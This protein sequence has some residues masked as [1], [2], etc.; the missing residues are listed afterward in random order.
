M[1]RF[2]VRS[3]IPTIALTLFAAGTL[4]SSPV[5]ADEA[6]DAF[7]RGMHELGRGRYDAACDAFEEAERHGGATM[8]TRYQLG[9][10]NQE[11]N[12]HV[13]SHRAFA[14]VARLATEAGDDK[15]AAIARQRMKEVAAH[16]GLL[17]IDVP[18]AT[19]AL[20]G[21]RIARDGEPVPP[22]D[23]NR[24]I[25]VA[26][27]PHTVTVSADDHQTLE[28]KVTPIPAGGSA[29]V[30]LPELTAGSGK[31][32]ADAP[33]PPDPADPAAPPPA[34]ADEGPRRASPALFWTGLAFVIAGPLTVAGSVY[35]YV[36][37]SQKEI[38]II[39][40]AVGG[41]LLAVGIPFM[42]VGGADA[43]PGER[44]VILEPQVG[45][46]WVGLSGRF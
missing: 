39:G 12:K 35:T 24:P 46:G 30:A 41:A 37:E 9:R 33:A 16:V 11:Q 17:T 32:A 6:D 31:T 28:L 34:A 7:N 4:W 5:L 42:V 13:A 15:R 45:P 25:A 29:A 40:M 20:P 10:C 22:R 38:G 1:S 44:A 14:D 27:G 2:S 26:P 21:L 23:F 3:A 19:A 43:E 18:A 8:K 36:E